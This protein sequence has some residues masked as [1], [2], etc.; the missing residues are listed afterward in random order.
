MSN[1]LSETKGTIQ[2]LQILRFF[3]ALVVVLDHCQFAGST[4][5]DRAGVSFAFPRFHG[6]LGVDIFFVISGFIMVYISSGRNVWATRPGAFIVDRIS[7][8]VPIYYIAT[9]LWVALFLAAAYLSN[10][11][12]DARWSLRDYILSALF[13][14]YLD[15]VT[16]LPQPVL[17]Q[18]WTLDYE[19]FFYALFAL[20]LTLTRARGMACLFFVFGSLA[21]AGQIWNVAGGDAFVLT[22]LKG[23]PGDHYF[24]VPR[25]WLHPIILEFLMGAALALLRERLIAAGMLVNLRY[26]TVILIVLI[27]A[28]TVAY[29]AAVVSGPILDA[30]RTLTAVGTVAVCVLTRDATPTSAL[31]DLSVECGNAS[32]SLYLCHAHILFVMLAVWKRVGVATAGLG[33]F[34]AVSVALCLIASLL[35]HRA[36]EKPLSQYVRRLMRGRIRQRLAV[37]MR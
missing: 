5:A 27:A 30:L 7:R 3:A 23:A 34:V 28:Y 14:P 33:S 36:V 37:T 8:I 20:V 9:A 2:S 25:F 1:T 21:I 22:P 6:R 4:L 35:L 31:R 16:G 12:F 19:V 29:N 26:T 18:G 32:Y 10:H 15:P 13:I 17:P 11:H 24:V